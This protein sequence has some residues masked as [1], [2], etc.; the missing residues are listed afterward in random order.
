MGYS[1]HYFYL[2]CFLYVKKSMFTAAVFLSSHPEFRPI[3][4][5][6]CNAIESKYIFITGELLKLTCLLQH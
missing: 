5:I 6:T 3:V 4:I 2:S 1:L